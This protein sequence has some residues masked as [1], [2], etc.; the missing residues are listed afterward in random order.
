MVIT[1]PVPDKVSI[2]LGQKN[3]EVPCK[4]LK[5]KLKINIYRLFFELPHTCLYKQS[6]LKG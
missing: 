1:R 5:D 2:D 3:R 4:A 6:F